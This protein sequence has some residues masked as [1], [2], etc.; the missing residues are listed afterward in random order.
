MCGICGIVQRSAD[1]PDAEL[2]TRM[3]KLLQHRGNDGRNVKR[4]PHA[5]LGHQR[6][7]IL[8]VSDKAS[9]PFSSRDGRYW[10]TFN[11]EIYNYPDI[12]RRLADTGPFVSTSDTEVLLRAFIEW[13]PDALNELN[14]MF[15]FAI[16]DNLAR[17]LFCARDRLGVKPFHYFYDGNSFVFA[18]EIKALLVHP[19]VTRSIDP[20]AVSDYLSLGYIAGDKTIVSGIK[21][22]LPGHLLELSPG[23][24]PEIREYWDLPQHIVINPA[25]AAGSVRHMLE[26]AC[27]ARLISDVPIGFFLSGGVDSSA[28][29]GYARRHHPQLE[30][31]SLGF[32][33]ST[34]NELDAAKRFSRDIMAK[35]H[36]V[37]FS[38]PDEKLLRRIAWSF[39]Q[40]FG[41]TSSVPTFKLCEFTSGFVKVAIS[42]DGGDEMFGGYETNRADI[43]AAVGQHAIPGW[44]SILQIAGRLWGMKSVDFGKISMDY[45]VRQFLRN[46]HLEPGRAHYSWRLLFDEQEKRELM[47]P[48]LWKSLN[49]YSPFEEFDRLYRKTADLGLFSRHMYVDLK[50]WLVDDILVK[51]DIAAMA[52]GLEVRNP[53]LDVH[54]V[55]YAAGIPFRMKADLFRTKK[56]LRDAVSD[57]VPDWIIKRKKEGFNSPVSHWL[58]GDLRPL[59]R[60]TISTDVFREIF[61][62]HDVLQ[63]IIDAHERGHRDWGHP[64]WALLMFG[65]WAQNYLK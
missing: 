46:A 13:G 22:L 8:D 65:L 15:A 6:L 25:E 11:G 35:S 23:N 1:T 32:E 59:L 57:V 61:P 33:T 38:A 36:G 9:Q 18:S 51:V 37:V 21:K 64:L 31:F 29:V 54:L 24:E 30:T 60:Q 55:E 63:T 4:F 42:G 26:A 28:I 3:M 56:V 53:F 2:L 10:I 17:R 50:T 34:F 40:P 20:R 48:V 45:K 49:G 58:R 52:H 19:R 16:W 47:S 5:G 14:G 27:R 7:A 39:D 43:A 41:D 12:K 62:H 44:K